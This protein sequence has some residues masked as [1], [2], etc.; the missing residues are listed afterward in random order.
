[1]FSLDFEKAAVGQIWMTQSSCWVSIF[2]PED[3]ARHVFGGSKDIRK[4]RA[5]AIGY[6]NAGKHAFD[7]GKQRIS[8][9]EHPTKIGVR[10]QTPRSGRSIIPN[11]RH[12]PEEA[13]TRTA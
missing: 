13:G 4:G 2:V 7:V 11:R 9:H 10:W 8:R 6:E 1:V 3:E 12:G 5:Q